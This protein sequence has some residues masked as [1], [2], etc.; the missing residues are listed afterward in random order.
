M[1]IVSN[2]FATTV[3]V[4]TPPALSSPSGGVERATSVERFETALLSA[5]DPAS[6]STETRGILDAGKA[7]TR[8]AETQIA[9]GFGSPVE[10]ATPPVASQERH[11]DMILDG[12]SYLRD[13]FD[14]QTERVGGITSMPISGTEKLIATQVEIVKFT[15]LMD[16]T[17]K[18]TGK[19]TQTFD[20]LMKGQ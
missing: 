6:T 14:R 17:S 7:Q 10:G 16:V 20:T 2:P 4:S 15:L 5:T 13:T 9:I 18:L 19:S 11:G 12:L 8:A 1:T 3:P